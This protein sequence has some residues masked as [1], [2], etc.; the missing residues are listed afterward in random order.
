MATVSN[1]KS[2]RFGIGR[3]QLVEVADRHYLVE[4]AVDKEERCLDMRDSVTRGEVIESVADGPLD[5]RQDE[6]PERPRN[7]RHLTTHQFSRVGR[8]SDGHDCLHIPAVR[9][10]QNGGTGTHRMTKDPNRG[11][12]SLGSEPR[13][14]DVEVLAEARH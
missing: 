3:G 6:F 9:C 13:H 5:R 10:T 14:G 11:H 4:S 8:G 7:P 2:L 1:H 12:I